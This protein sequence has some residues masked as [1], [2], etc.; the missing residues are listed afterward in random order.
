M[1]GRLKL[2][3]HSKILTVRDSIQSGKIQITSKSRCKESVQW[4]LF[5]GE[6]QAV[7]FCVGISKIMCN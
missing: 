1:I 2:Q 3:V 4:V 5:I 6:S 7:S